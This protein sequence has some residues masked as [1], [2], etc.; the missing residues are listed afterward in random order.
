MGRICYLILSLIYGL[1]FVV[2]LL[3]ADLLATVCTLVLAVFYAMLC[4][5]EKNG[6]GKKGR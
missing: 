5:K 2:F 1:L 4:R 3:C 6:C